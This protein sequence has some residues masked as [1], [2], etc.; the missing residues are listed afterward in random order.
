ME[1]LAQGNGNVRGAYGY[2]I[3]IRGGLAFHGCA[4]ESS[5]AWKAG[6]AIGVALIAAGADKPEGSPHREYWCI[7]HRT[8]SDG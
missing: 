8:G 6:V 5:T 7:E 2:V 4:A 1:R 3:G